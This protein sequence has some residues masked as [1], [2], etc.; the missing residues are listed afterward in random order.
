M[1][2]KPDI[3]M[4]AA[5]GLEGLPPWAAV[6]VAVRA[7]WRALPESYGLPPEA[8]HDVAAEVVAAAYLGLGEGKRDIPVIYVATS[9][10]SDSSIS[11]NAAHAA[12]SAAKAATAEDVT[13]TELA[14]AAVYS[15]IQAAASADAEIAAVDA[16]TSDIN[17]VNTKSSIDDGVDPDF[18][19]R[20]LWSRTGKRSAPEA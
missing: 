8:M 4:A 13:T 3:A 10:A 16:V 15:A 14:T 7:V 2:D 11:A 1:A 9:A 12:A 6:A 5:K 20:R 17:W 18:F 19:R